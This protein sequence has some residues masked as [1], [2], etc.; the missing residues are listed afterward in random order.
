MSDREENP[1]AANQDV[2]FD[3]LL[4]LFERTQE[5][6]RSQAARSVDIA[7]VVRNWLFGWYI[8][9]FENG[10]AE[11]AELYG[12]ALI[13]KLSKQLTQQL[14]RGFSKRSLEQF[15]SFYVAFSEI[16]QTLSAQSPSLPQVLLESTVTR[17]RQGSDS[18]GRGVISPVRTVPRIEEVWQVLSIQFTLSWSH[19]VA[20][21]TIKSTDERRFYE[22]EAR[23]NN[24]GVREL[25]R[26][27]GS[28]L[29]ER[30]ALSRDKEKVKELSEK[31]QLIDR[32]ECRPEKPLCLGV[33]GFGR[34]VRLLGISICPP[35]MN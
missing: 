28:S 25:K 8:V 27:I 5:A 29:Y 10:G 33:S 26:Q 14:G 20:L 17:P 18:D 24:W 11:R 35:K 15:R 13:E 6:M 4:G 12:K 22:I 32:P 30:L 34:A 9:E 16:A 7:L 21:L 1:V 2:G 19:Y 3:R 31:G 23:E